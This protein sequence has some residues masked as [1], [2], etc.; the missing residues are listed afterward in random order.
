MLPRTQFFWCIYGLSGF[1]SEIM[2]FIVNND[3]VVLWSAS[4][5]GVENK[6]N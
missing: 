1:I 6:K 2:K 5:R 4:I 3:T